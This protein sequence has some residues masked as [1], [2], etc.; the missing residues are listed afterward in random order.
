MEQIIDKRV[1]LALSKQQSQQG[2]TDEM[3]P[4]TKR[5]SS[6]ASTDAAPATTETTAPAK[7]AA[8]PAS[9]E[10]QERYPVDDITVRSACELLAQVRNKMILVAYGVAEIPAPGDSITGHHLSVGYY[11]K[12]F[13]DRVVDSWADLELEIPGPDGE[14]YLGDAVHGWIF[15]T[16]AHLKIMQLAPPP[17][18]D[19]TTSPSAMPEGQDQLPPSPTARVECSMSHVV[20]RDP[21][22]GP[23]VKGKGSKRR[24]RPRPPPPPPMK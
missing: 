22:E 6:V 7:E 11:A 21:S 10:N 12:V 18:A 8:P 1:A 9:P 5:K 14:E 19:S 20:D 3:S 16:K 15:W 4:S 24:A 2:P 23:P 13:L 17:P